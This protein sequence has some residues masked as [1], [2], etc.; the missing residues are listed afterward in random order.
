[1]SPAGVDG[2]VALAASTGPPPP[3]AVQIGGQAATVSYA[4]NAPGMVEGALQVNAVVPTTVTPGSA[5]S[6]VVT[7]GTTASP[8]TATLAV[9]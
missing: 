4:G 5:V 6:V 2:L 1:M 3:V 8:A 7:V 9:Q